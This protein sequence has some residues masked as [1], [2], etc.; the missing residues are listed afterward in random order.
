MSLPFGR[1]LNNRINVD[2]SATRITA[3]T[4]DINSK[5]LRQI[6]LQGR[7]W[8]EENAPEMATDG[9]GA[10]LMFAYISERNINGMLGGTTLALI[11]ISFI[12]MFALRSVKYGFLSLIPN[13][14]PA[15]VSFGIWGLFVG[16]VGMSL[17]VVT[18]M[19][20]G[21]VVD[22]TVHFLSKYL[23]ARREKELSAEDA[24]RYAFKSV[25]SALVSTSAIL[26]AGF[27]VLSVSS[28]AQNGDMGKMAAITIIVALIAD[29]LF[30][31]PLLIL[32]ESSKRSSSQTTK[33]VDAN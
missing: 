26:V 15:A 32:L 22:D 11:G 1:D 6:A 24:V 8:L 9:V 10:A 19:T 31:P 28:F 21:I 27:L 3:T 12:L 33:M 29:F 18:A 30:L 5:R 7:K 17:S 4:G 20:L 13:L 14:L 23:Q 25:G 2:K 16:K